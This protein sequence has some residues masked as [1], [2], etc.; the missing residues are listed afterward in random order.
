MSVYKLLG[1]DKFIKRIFQWQSGKLPIFL[2]LV[3]GS[4]L[5]QTIFVKSF[6]EDISF[7]MTKIQTNKQTYKQTNRGRDKKK[8]RKRKNIKIKPLV[9]SGKNCAWHTFV[10]SRCKGHM[11]ERPSRILRV[12]RQKSLKFFSAIAETCQMM[13]CQILISEPCLP[14][15]ELNI[16]N[17]TRRR[18]CRRLVEFL[19][20]NSIHWKKSDP[21]C[22]EKRVN[23]NF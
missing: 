9:P 10:R 5:A 6:I 16:K 3:E 23:H 2:P 18:L 13:M 22:A 1:Y 19:M 11:C 20:F 17:S 15:A 4:S 8:Y 14:K 21:A 12:T 7:V